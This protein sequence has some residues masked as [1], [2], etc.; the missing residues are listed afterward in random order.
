[1]GG[2]KQV[3]CKHYNT[4]CK[5]LEHPLILISTGNPGTSP[6]WYWGTTVIGE[7]T[8]SLINVN[9]GIRTPI[10]LDPKHISFWHPESSVMWTLPVRGRYSSLLPSLSFSTTALVMMPGR[11]GLPLFPIYPA[12]FSNFASVLTTWGLAE[13]ILV[14]LTGW[15]PVSVATWKLILRKGASLDTN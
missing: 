6:P 9:T 2:H 10:F 13:F 15:G 7:Y 14:L 12:T 11:C 4:L 8:H 5:G 3:P 1:M